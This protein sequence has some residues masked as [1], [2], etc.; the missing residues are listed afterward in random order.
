M[1][2]IQIELRHNLLYPFMLIIFNIFRKIDSIIISK[3]LKFNSSLIMTLLMFL[4]EFIAGK[5]FTKTKN[6]I[7]HGNKIN[8]SK[9]RFKTFR[10]Q[11]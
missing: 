10:H 7:F 3:F 2:F 11:N 5:F 4:G 9:I 8:S 6:N 1:K